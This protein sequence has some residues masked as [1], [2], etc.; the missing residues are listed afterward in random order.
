MQI[1]CCRSQRRSRFP[2][3]SRVPWCPRLPRLPPPPRL[4]RAHRQINHLDKIPLLPPPNLPNWHNRH[5]LPNERPRHQRALHP[6]KIKPF[7]LPPKP[8][9]QRPL[10]PRG[11]SLI[12]SQCPT[13]LRRRLWSHRYQVW[14]YCARRLY[15]WQSYAYV[16][17]CALY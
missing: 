8:G 7:L 3:F 13:R 16:V 11:R 17:G 5:P 1:W 10:L 2:W 4:Q 9:L 12:P 15:H 14:T 6:P